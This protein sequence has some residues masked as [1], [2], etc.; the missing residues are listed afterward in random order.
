[1]PVAAYVLMIDAYFVP[2]GGHKV[3]IDPGGSSDQ[4]A[5]GPPG[6]GGPPANGR[7]RRQAGYRRATGRQAG[8]QA[9]GGPP[10]DRRATRR[11]AGHRGICRMAASAEFAWSVQGHKRGK[12]PPCM[13]WRGLA[14][15][16]HAD[17]PIAR[18]LALIDRPPGPETRPK[19]RFPGSSCVA[20]V[21]PGWSP[22]PATREFVLP[23]QSQHKRFPPTISR[24][25]LIHTSSTLPAPVIP[26]P[27]RIST[28][29]P[30]PDPQAAGSGSA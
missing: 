30:Q 25:F 22:F 19:H 23:P 14:R 3:G 27:R 10:G 20:G 13:R 16:H 2:T 18:P 12:A 8:H 4:N 6:D 7:Y 17:L 28:I 21:S 1:M 11:Q 29:H 26:R 24:I 5:A 9:T 15:S